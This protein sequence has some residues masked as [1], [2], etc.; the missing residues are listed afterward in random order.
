MSKATNQTTKSIFAQRLE[1]LMKENNMIQ[2]DV[3][4]AAGVTRQNVGKW[5]NKG[6]NPDVITAAKIAE[7][8]NVSVDYLVGY[9]D[10]KAC[11][12]HDK[13]SSIHTGLNDEAVA[14]LHKYY[15]SAVK[16]FRHMEEDTERNLCDTTND[17]GYTRKFALEIISELISNGD[18]F[19]LAEALLDLKRESQNFANYN[20]AYYINK[21]Q[22]DE[23]GDDRPQNEKDAEL[24]R[25]NV[26][27]KQITNSI[28]VYRYAL[29]EFIVHLSDRYDQREQVKNNGNNNPTNK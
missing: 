12:F 17:I 2:D 27:N 14:S 23:Q 9:L 29:I 4:Q 24:I 19:K 16:N 13:I 22:R 6:S 20:E 1:G 15:D 21:K 5:L 7:F 28:N 3:A 25:K 10:V 26:R 18:M 11:D 8:F